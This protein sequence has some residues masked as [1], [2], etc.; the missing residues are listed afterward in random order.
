MWARWVLALGIATILAV[1][2]V[3]YVDRHNTDSLAPESPTAAVRANQ[4]A[5]IVV[6]QDQAPHVVRL[7]AATMGRAGFAT[8]IRADVSRRIASGQISGP[9]R[10]VRCAS[11]GSSAG[12][13]AFSCT[14]A[15][16]GFNYAFVGVID[17]RARR[18]TYCKRDPPPVPSQNVPVSP[19]CRI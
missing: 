9:L 19:R 8:I 10:S 13:S 17:A 3:I 4:E 15:A 16:G 2:L 18:V 7:T 11:A 6:A 1:A 12:R 14:A 5:E